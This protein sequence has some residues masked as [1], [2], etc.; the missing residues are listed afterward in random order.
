MSGDYSDQ[1]S[2]IADAIAD[3]LTKHDTKDT[4]VQANLA[5][6]K[7]LDD[8]KNILNDFHASVGITLRF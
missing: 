6:F 4:S 7:A 1:V 2:H 5:Y 3:L 8:Y